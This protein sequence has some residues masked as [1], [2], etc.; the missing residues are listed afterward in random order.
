M[1]P[2]AHDVR[3]AAQSL[4]V[5]NCEDCHSPDLPFFFGKVQVDSPIKGKA[6]Y[7]VM[8]DI[9]EFAG[10]VYVRVNLF[11]KWLIIVTMGL[12]IMHI[13]GDLYRRVILRLFKKSG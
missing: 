11:F 4:G 1:W 12:L 7:R 10:P 6:G 5:R 3:P 9:Y 13:L 8:K 2:I